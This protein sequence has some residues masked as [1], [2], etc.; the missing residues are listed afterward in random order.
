MTR[1]LKKYCRCYSTSSGPRIVIR[2]IKPRGDDP[3]K[4]ANTTYS[5]EVE[6]VELACDACD[7]EWIEEC[8]K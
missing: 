3:T 5:A 7:R 4:Y 6:F 1:R 8:A 2:G